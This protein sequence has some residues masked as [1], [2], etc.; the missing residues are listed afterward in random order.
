MFI[1]IFITFQA[2]ALTYLVFIVVVTVALSIASFGVAEDWI[3][4]RILEM[5]L[6]QVVQATLG[7]DEL[8]VNCKLKK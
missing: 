6:E 5:D 4:S 7:L 1:V 8:Q 3:D 2:M